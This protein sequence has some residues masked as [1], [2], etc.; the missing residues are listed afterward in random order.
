MSIGG[1]GNEL[2]AQTCPFSG[3]GEVESSPEVMERA[4]LEDYQDEEAAAI[5]SRDCQD[6]PDYVFLNLLDA[7]A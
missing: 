6:C 7:N 2:V 3:L 4:A 1:H 5:C